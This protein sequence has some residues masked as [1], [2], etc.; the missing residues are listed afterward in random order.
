MKKFNKN[1]LF[2][3]SMSSIQ[4]DGQG[5]F[6]Y[7]RTNYDLLFEKNREKFF[8]GIGPTKT[9]DFINTYKQDL[10]LLKEIGIKALRHSFSWAKL[11]PNGKNE[12]PDKNVIKYYHDLINEMRKNDIT[13]MM[14]LMH[15]EIPEYISLEGG[16]ISK[17][18][19]NDFTNFGEFILKEYGNELD[20]IATFNEPFVQATSSY[21][22]NGEV[23]QWPL[24]DSDQDC[25]LAI[26]NVI[27]ANARITKIHKKMNLKSKIGIVLDMSPGYP[28]NINNP[29]DMET[30][31]D[32]TAF[33]EGIFLDPTI[34]GVYCQ[35]MRE[36]NQKLG[37]KSLFDLKE[38]NDLIKN[39]P[40]TWL[41]INYYSPIW[42]K[43]G[44]KDPKRFIDLFTV[45]DNPIMTMNKSRG[46]EIS[47]KTLYEI[48]MRIKNDYHN[49]EWMV[50]ENGIGIANEAEDYTFQGQIVD[51]YRIKFLKM[52]LDE[53]HKAI[54][55]GSNCVGYLMWTPIDSWSFMNGYKNRYGLISLNLET[56]EKTIK[57]SGYWWKQMVEDSGYE[58]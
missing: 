5:P 42:F 50:T 44:S 31:L 14:T 1:F 52:H 12:Q 32:W 8:N 2:G 6:Q 25:L 41:G 38:N 29:D 46:W 16:M 53:L 20:Y 36:I 43:A 26:E 10:K 15:F 30:I 47:P 27:L 18:F 3:G 13:P 57:K 22:T 56:Y 28:R 51:D 55:D 48:G 37:L 58:S 34:N 11:F 40:A 35:R 7:S 9:N 17:T 39:N 33:R 19:V 24:G 23:G 4:S 54:Q 45:W 21:L 49:I